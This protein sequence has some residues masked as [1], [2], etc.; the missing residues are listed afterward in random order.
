MKN[1]GKQLLEG[2]WEGLKAGW[3]WLK[4]KVPELWNKFVEK[5]KSFFGIH[6]PST[7]FADFG[8]FM[9]DGLY[10]GLTK[11]IEK[12]KEACKKVWEAIKGCFAKVGDWFKETFSKAWQKVKDVFSKGSQIFSGIKEGIADTFK[13]IVNTLITGINKIISIPFNNINGMLNKIREISIAKVKPFEKLWSHNPLPV[14]QIPKLARGGIVNNPGAGVPLI[15]GEAG[16]E[17][18]LPL[19]NNTEWMDILADKIGGG[20]GGNTTI[21][22]YLDGKMIA[23]YIIDLQKRKAFATNGG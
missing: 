19:D 9:M 7:M 3:E 1:G 6:S 17:A 8:G 2:L 21:P 5:F 18:I 23:K 11:A 16:R 4:V 12:I 15:A 10:N 14:P 22:V 20:G 13:T